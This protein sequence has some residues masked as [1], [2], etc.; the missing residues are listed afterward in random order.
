MIQ[1]NY[2]Y[3]GIVHRVIDGDTFEI[4]IDLGF[5]LKITKDIRL[6]DVDTPET[7]RPRNEAE[8]LHGKAA[9][10]F[11]KNLIEGKEVVLQSVKFGKYRYV[12]SV[13]VEVNGEQLNLAEELT[14]NGMLKKENY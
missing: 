8:K 3:K 1:P 10:E 2:V 11:V 12:A 7:W 14:N 4:E 13:F 9:T 6:L 5:D